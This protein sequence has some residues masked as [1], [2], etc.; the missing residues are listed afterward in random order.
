M[1]RK[2]SSVRSVP[3]PGSKPGVPG[4]THFFA[5]VDGKPRRVRIKRETAPGIWLAHLKGG[6]VVEV[7]ADTL[8]S[9]R[10][11]A[12]AKRAARVVEAT[13]ADVPP[14]RPAAVSL[15][16]EEPT[17]GMQEL[18]GALTPPADD[19]SDS[20]LPPAVSPLPPEPEGAPNIPPPV[21]A[22]GALHRVAFVNVAPS[23]TPPPT[24]PEG[25][26]RLRITAYDYPGRRRPQEE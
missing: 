10:E 22:L 7:T 18:E 4:Q 5:V 13:L 1:G 23:A 11:E 20:M 24:A 26:R 21:P 19:S 9:T 3:G 14:P 25:P 12:G 2:K 8:G 6:E 16:A 17:P 15:P